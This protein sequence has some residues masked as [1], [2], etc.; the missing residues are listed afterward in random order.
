M[1]YGLL[2]PFHTKRR[3]FVSELQGLLSRIGAVGIHEELGIADC[4]ARLSDAL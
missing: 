3:E 4:I 1:I 2:K